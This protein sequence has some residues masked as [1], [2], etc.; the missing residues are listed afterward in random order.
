MTEEE[1]TPHQSQLRKVGP[2]GGVTEGS[3]AG[4]AG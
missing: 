1:E 4:G 3:R 2:G